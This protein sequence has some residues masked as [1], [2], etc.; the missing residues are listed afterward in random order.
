MNDKLRKLAEDADEEYSLE[1]VESANNFAFYE[2]AN[3]QAILELLNE[4]TALQN[5]LDWSVNLLKAVEDCPMCDGSGNIERET[6][7]EPAVP[8]A[9][10]GERDAFLQEQDE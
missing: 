5:R 1:K 2:A 8:C 9:W 7:H 3:P 4:I 6:I 10:C